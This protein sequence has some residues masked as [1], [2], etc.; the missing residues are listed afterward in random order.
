MGRIDFADIIQ[1]AQAQRP[2]LQRVGVQRQQTESK[3]DLQNN[4]KAPS[5]D[6]TVVG[7]QDIGQGKDSLNRNELYL[8]LN[9]DIPLQRRVVSGRTQAAAANIL[10]LKWERNLLEGR[11]VAKAANSLFKAH[12]DYQA[13]LGNEVKLREEENLE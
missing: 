1:T 8:G 2:E 12:A 4:Q 9:I 13:V 11:I 10:R 7:A 3:L 5:V 6:L